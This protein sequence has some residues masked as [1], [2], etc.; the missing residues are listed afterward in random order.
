MLQHRGE[1]R[2]RYWNMS[3]ECLD[4]LPLGHRASRCKAAKATIC[5]TF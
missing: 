3:V 5:K 1:S 4:L 2:L